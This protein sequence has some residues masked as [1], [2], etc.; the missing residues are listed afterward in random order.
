[1]NVCERRTPV[2]KTHIEQNIYP[3]ITCILV[4]TMST[5]QNITAKRLE[6]GEQSLENL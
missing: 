2:E 5:I 4:G 1:V 3:G 6:G